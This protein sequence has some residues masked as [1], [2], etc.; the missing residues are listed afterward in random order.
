MLG[1]QINRLKPDA[2]KLPLFQSP[3]QMTPSAPSVAAVVA[4]GLNVALPVLFPPV[5]VASMGVV[6]STPINAVV[7]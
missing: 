1:E 5:P 6:L 2:E 4:P 3:Q 7:T